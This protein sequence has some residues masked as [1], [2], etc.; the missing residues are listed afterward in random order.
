MYLANSLAL[1]I[2]GIW[3]GILGL[4]RNDLPEIKGGTIEKDAQ[5]F[6]TGIFKDNALK[7]VFEKIPQP[8]DEVYFQ[9]LK[10]AQDYVKKNG[11][12]SIHHMTEP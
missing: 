5:G 1:K 7:L 11:V 4:M 2:C 9:Y 12:T 10:S 6:P 3:Q 8:S